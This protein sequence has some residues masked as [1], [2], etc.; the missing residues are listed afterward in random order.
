MRL[1][2]I[3][4]ALSTEYPNPS[5]AARILPQVVFLSSKVI[6][7]LA[8]LK[9]TLAFMTPFI[10]RR[11]LPMRI[12]QLVQV[13]PSILHFFVCTI[14]T[15]YMYHDP[16]GSVYTR[17]RYHSSSSCLQ[18]AVYQS[19]VWVLCGFLHL[20]K[21]SAPFVRA[22]YMNIQYKKGVLEL[23]T[24]SFRTVRMRLSFSGRNASVGVLFFRVR[25][26]CPVV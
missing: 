14:C 13:M 20:E 8:V 3:P 1:G 5:M 2:E 24:L 25:G 21:I 12:S 22:G 11:V 16:F 15:S 17:R 18:M 4:S 6:S 19:F 10:A 9:D 26:L 7:A 23:C